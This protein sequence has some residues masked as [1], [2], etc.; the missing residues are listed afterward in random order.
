MENRSP[1]QTPEPPYYAVIFTSL[2]TEGERGYGKMAERMM[3]LA[4]NQPG[5]LGA[6]TDHQLA[7]ELG[8]DVWYSA[9]ELRVAKVE[10]AYG[11]RTGA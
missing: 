5:F 2:R 11:K 9:Y 4:R 8:R 7:Q 3:D 6:D 10:R 1:A